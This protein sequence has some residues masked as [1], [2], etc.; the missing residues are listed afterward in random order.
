MKPVRGETGEVGAHPSTFLAIVQDYLRTDTKSKQTRWNYLVTLSNRI[1]PL[2]HPSPPPKAEGILQIIG[3]GHPVHSFK[4]VGWMMAIKEVGP[5]HSSSVTYHHLDRLLFSP[6]LM[7]ATMVAPIAKPARR[8]PYL[9]L[10]E[11]VVWWR[12]RWSISS[13]PYEIISV[14]LISVPRQNHVFG[15]LSSD[16]LAEILIPEIL[17]PTPKSYLSKGYYS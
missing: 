4:M 13:W 17:I 2:T 5:W 16:P 10:L 8:L 14:S 3:L 15:V 9:L 6:T 11:V 1:Q 12:G 7:R